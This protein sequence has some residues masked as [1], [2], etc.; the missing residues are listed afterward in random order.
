M[1]TIGIF[2]SG[3]GGLSV[4]RELVKVL[5]KE[6]DAGKRIVLQVL[7]G[8]VNDIPG[9][10]AKAA[11]IIT[12]RG[13]SC[14]GECI[15]NDSKRPVFIEYLIPVLEAATCDH[16]QDRRIAGTAFRKDQRAFQDSLTVA[17][18]DLLLS[19]RERPFW[20]LWPIELLFAR[21]KR[22]GHRSTH[23]L[24]GTRNLLD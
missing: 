12:E 5:P 10:F 3:C 16:N 23:L 1:A 8:A 11:V 21:H 20:C 2:D 22:Q 9:G 7:C 17:E 15:G 13:N 18:R 24:E 6:S 14:A 19:I 4:Y